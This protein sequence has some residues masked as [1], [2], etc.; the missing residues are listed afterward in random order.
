MQHF[1]EAENNLGSKTLVWVTATNSACPCCA[2]G[3]M[4]AFLLCR[5]EAPVSVCYWCL[6]Q[7]SLQG[8]SI[9]YNSAHLDYSGG[10]QMKTQGHLQKHLIIALTLPAL[11]YKCSQA[12]IKFPSAGSNK[13]YVSALYNSY[14]CSFCFTLGSCLPSPFFTHNLTIFVIYMP[15]PV[16]LAKSWF[17]L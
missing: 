16:F 5:K 7:P 15:L 11:V 12:L 14:F 9:P 4:L 3:A 1:H 10:T 6:A 2:H 13:V 8:N 17:L